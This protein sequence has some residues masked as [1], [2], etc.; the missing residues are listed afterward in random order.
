MHAKEH[1][2]KIIECE[3]KGEEKALKEEV[4]FDVSASNGAHV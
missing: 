2:K 1:A 4:R 3:R